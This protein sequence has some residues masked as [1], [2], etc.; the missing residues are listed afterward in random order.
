M[1]VRLSARAR[2]EV[3]R[4]DAWWQQHRPAVP[5]LFVDEL[6]ATLTLIEKMPE[7]G[8]SYDAGTRY[9]VQRLLMK[10]TSYHAYYVRKSDDLIVV[11]SVWGARRKR[12]PRLR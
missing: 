1:K 8:Q 5:T 2:R 10:K 7:L 4:I 11:V 12:G 6:S 9:L 3:K